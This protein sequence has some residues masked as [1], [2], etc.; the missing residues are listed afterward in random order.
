MDDAFIIISGVF[1]ALWSFF[2]FGLIKQLKRSLITLRSFGI[3]AGALIIGEL[4]ISYAVFFSESSV[5]GIIFFIIAFA[6]AIASIL[7]IT[8]KGDAH[9]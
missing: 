9:E 1:L 6:N 7:A 5:F 4:A 8:R 2:I 3:Y